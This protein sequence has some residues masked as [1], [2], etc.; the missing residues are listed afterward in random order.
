M[1]PMEALITES[2]IKSSNQHTS[3]KIIKGWRKK[4]DVEIQPGFEPGSSEF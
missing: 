4:K 1:S 2:N 3:K